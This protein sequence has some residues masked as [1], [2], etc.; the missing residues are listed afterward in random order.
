MAAP[1][2]SPAACVAAWD[3]PCSWPCVPPAAAAWDIPGELDRRAG[4][5]LPILACA[6]AWPLLFSGDRSAVEGTEG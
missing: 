3:K 1:S 5:S 2:V 6:S 4:A